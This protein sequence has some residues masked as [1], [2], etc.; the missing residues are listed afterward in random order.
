M[1]IK[2][3]IVVSIAAGFAMATPLCGLAMAELSASKEFAKT[4]RDIEAMMKTAEISLTAELP[5]S[6]EYLAYYELIREK[7]K[8]K[9][10]T[11][12][13]NYYS[14]GDVNLVFTLNRDGS[15]SDV[16][17]DQE[18]STSDEALAGI[19]VS[20]IKAAS[21]FPSFPSELNLPQASFNLTVSFR[22]Q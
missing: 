5:S 13:R 8:R 14:Y 2:K 15:L 11:N 1:G 12:Y 19:A 6:R 3:I 16:G 22:K 18:N 20:S 9:L 7:I 4:P 17:I 10:R 21:P